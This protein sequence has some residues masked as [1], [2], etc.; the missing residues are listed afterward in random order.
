MNTE[1]DHSYFRVDVLESTD[2]AVKVKLARDATVH[3]VPKSVCELHDNG[4]L[5]V[6]SWFAEKEGLD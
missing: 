4:T 1:N 5:E 3:W 6:E 2:R